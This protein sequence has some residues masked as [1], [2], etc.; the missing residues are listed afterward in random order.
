[1]NSHLSYKAMANG[2][3]RTDLIMPMSH[4][5][6]PDRSKQ[7]AHSDTRLFVCFGVF[8]R[9]FFGQIT[10]AEMAGKCLDWLEI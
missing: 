9:L 10:S 4:V 8:L 1:M 5:I 3:W 2:L 6:L 7:A